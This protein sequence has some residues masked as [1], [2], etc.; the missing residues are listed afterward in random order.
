[1]WKRK[2]RLTYW[3]AG[4]QPSDEPSFVEWLK[5]KLRLRFSLFPISIKEDSM[6]IETRTFDWEKDLVVDTHVHDG[7][8]SINAWTERSSAAC[9]HDGYS[10]RVRSIELLAGAQ[11]Q[12][13]KLPNKQEAPIRQM[14]LFI[15]GGCR[16]LSIDI[17]LKGAIHEMGYFINALPKIIDRKQSLIGIA[18]V[19]SRLSRIEIFPYKRT[20][21]QIC[22]LLDSECQS[23]LHE[24]EAIKGIPVDRAELLAVFRHIPIEMISKMRYLAENKIILYTICRGIRRTHTRVHDMAAIR[25]TGSQDI[26]LVPHR[27]RFQSV[28][29]N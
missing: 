5:E 8:L 14:N 4:G 1:M 23:F 13:L 26:F 6:P 19:G 16:S 17:V 7:L 10:G 29:L 15:R 21:L 24:A 12:D 2:E 18:Q 27:S 22:E 9:R 25:D 28:Y 11:V 3:L 20:S